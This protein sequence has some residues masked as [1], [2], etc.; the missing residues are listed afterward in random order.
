MQVDMHDFVTMIQPQNVKLK[1]CVMVGFLLA[2]GL[3]FQCQSLIGMEPDPACS[4]HHWE[5]QV[6]GKRT[7]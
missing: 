4:G 2:D 1:A 5:W 7:H 6:R 3:G